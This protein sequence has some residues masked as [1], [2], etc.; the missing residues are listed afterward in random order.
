[1]TLIDYLTLSGINAQT[2]EDELL[3]TNAWRYF[4]GIP[5][6]FCIVFIIGMLTL[7]RLDTPMYLITQQRYEEAKKSIAHFSSSYQDQ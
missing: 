4:I 1:V 6:L 7:V 3:K 5:I 2:Q